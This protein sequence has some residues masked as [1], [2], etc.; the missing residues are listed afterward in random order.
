[1]RIFP[2]GGTNKYED[3]HGFIMLRGLVVLLIVMFC[4]AVMIMGL[5]IMSRRSIRVL[6]ETRKEIIERNES[7]M[8][9]L[10]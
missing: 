9:K 1:M 10:R 5:T 8:R 6:E 2:H 7:V 3:E 4:F